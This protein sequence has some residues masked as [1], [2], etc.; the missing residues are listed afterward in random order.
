MARGRK[1]GW[2]FILYFILFCRS[3]CE[4]GL[5]ILMQTLFPLHF[6]NSQSCHPVQSLGTMLT[7]VYSLQTHLLSASGGWTGISLTSLFWN[8]ISYKTSMLAHLVRGV[9]Y[10]ILAL[11]T[12]LLPCLVTLEFLFFIFLLK[13]I[14]IFSSRVHYPIHL[15]L[16]LTCQ[17]LFLLTF[18]SLG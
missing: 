3:H 17:P 1:Q 9:T 16:S 11:P 13:T 5:E 10:R 6:M 18:C 8:M 15:I 12:L 2:V 4:D 14:A 7:V